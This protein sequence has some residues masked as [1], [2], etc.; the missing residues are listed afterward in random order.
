MPL[1]VSWLPELELDDLFISLP[2]ISSFSTIK[3]V[4]LIKVYKARPG[5][6]PETRLKLSSCVR[7]IRG[8]VA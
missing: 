6:D 1:F 2:A 8:P 7:L 5:F 3:I 4:F